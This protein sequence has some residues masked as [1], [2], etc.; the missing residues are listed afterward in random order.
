MIVGDKTIC[1]KPIANL[2]HG[3]EK[4]INVCCDDCGINYIIIWHNYTE[5]QKKKNNDGTT[6]CRACCI[7]RAAAANKEKPNWAKGKT[8]PNRQGEKAPSWKGG[9]YISNDGY[10]MVYRKNPNAKS[11]WEHYRKEHLIIAEEILGRP[12]AEKEVVH[13]INLNKLDNNPDNLFVCNNESQHQ[14]L[15]MQLQS[16]AKM[17]LQANLIVFDKT[18]NTYV[19]DIKLCEL[20]EH[21]EADNQQPSLESD[22]SE[23]STTSENNLSEIMSHHERRAAV[24]IYS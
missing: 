14:S 17:L 1:G 9:S 3:S 21:P 18:S 19:A 8:F 11:K 22:L 10:K 13:H 7:K 5:R 6:Y 2:T 20:L 12:L 24:T 15:H 16:I 4:R 23:G